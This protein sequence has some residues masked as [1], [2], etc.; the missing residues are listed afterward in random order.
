M[1]GKKRRVS[2]G[3]DPILPDQGREAPWEELGFT[4]AT[5]LPAGVR[6]GVSPLL[7]GAI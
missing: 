6:S 1:G 5:P 3:S 7:A 2:P 4:K